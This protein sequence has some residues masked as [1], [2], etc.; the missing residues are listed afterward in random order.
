V[1]DTEGTVT[2]LLTEPPPTECPMLGT[3]WVCAWC[4]YHGHCPVKPWHD[5]H[6]DGTPTRHGC[7]RCVALGLPMPPRLEGP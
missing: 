5:L 1:A 3:P 2:D 6:H 7:T 4:V